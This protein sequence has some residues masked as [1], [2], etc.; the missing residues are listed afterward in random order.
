MKITVL[1]LTYNGARWVQPCLKSVLAA[2]PPAAEI[3][4]VDNQSADETVE[5]IRS[6]F[7]QVK[8]LVNERNLGF[9]AGVNQGIRQALA[10]GADFVLLLNQDTQVR[11]DWIGRLM[12][13]VEERGAVGIFS[14]LQLNY[15][16]TA[17]DPGN[18]QN[19]AENVPQ[20]T[21]DA[22]LGRVKGSYPTKL[23]YG[24]AMMIHREVI[25]RIGF[26]DEIFFMYGE[27]IDF[28]HRAVRC[29]VPIWV[30]PYANVYHYSSMSS[31]GADSPWIQRAGRR[32]WIVLDLKDPRRAFWV[33]YLVQM[34]SRATRVLLSVCF[35]RLQSLANSLG[36]WGWQLANV[37][38]IR[39]SR[40]RD[41]AFLRTWR[42]RIGKGSSKM[43]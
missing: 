39:R 9:A 34:R 8:L 28:C 1:I 30:V 5:F 18:R 21:D 24:G 37:W 36:D 33:S 41:E 26:F 4:V 27:D 19:L 38:R 14:P 6:Q 16:G 10:G 22:W 42:E 31:H 11:Q 43:S 25:E 15:D 29:D 17:I 12:S 40:Q 3:L 35:G 32:V 13:A 7:P 20:F 2:N 23:A